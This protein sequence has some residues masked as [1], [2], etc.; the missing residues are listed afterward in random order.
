[1]LLNCINSII[2]VNL[3]TN[4]SDKFTS[5]IFEWSASSK[6]LSESIAKTICRLSV[7]SLKRSAIIIDIQSTVNGASNNQILR[8]QDMFVITKFYC[9]E[10]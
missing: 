3:C 8:G 2:S 1:M 10:K 7:I 6:I 9:C 5:N 4:S